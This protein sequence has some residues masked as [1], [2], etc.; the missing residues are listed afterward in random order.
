MHIGLERKEGAFPGR[1]GEDRAERAEAI[2]VGFQGMSHVSGEDLDVNQIDLLDI[3]E[4]ASALA[5]SP[6]AEII[7]LIGWLVGC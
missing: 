5:S 7:R 6:S 2:K 3:D 4:V 1:K